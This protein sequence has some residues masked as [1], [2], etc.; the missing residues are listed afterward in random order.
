MHIQNTELRA[1]MTV[2]RMWLRLQ[3]TECT[4]AAHHVLQPVMLLLLILC[5]V[6]SR[7]MFFA[8]VAWG[9]QVVE[10]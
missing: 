2:I 6:P 1:H 9:V 4:L 3:A 7:A 10:M 5:A 8:V